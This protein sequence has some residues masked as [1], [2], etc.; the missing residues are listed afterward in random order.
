MARADKEAT[1]EEVVK[2][3]V[4]QTLGA[5]AITPDM[6]AMIGAAVAAAVK[7]AKR[8]EDYEKRKAEEE[9]NREM[10]RREEE[11]RLLNIRARQ[12]QCPHLDAY[13]NHAFV[14]QKNCLGQYVFICSQCF[15]AFK[16]EDPDYANFVRFVKVEKMGNAR[17]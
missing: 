14:G 3:E 17:N 2:E 1:A 11:Q 5:S 9:S 16:P 4:R 13:E 6:L 12:D 15:R 7:E 10:V 8:D